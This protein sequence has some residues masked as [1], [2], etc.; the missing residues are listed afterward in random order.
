ML[1]MMELLKLLA[2]IEKGRS[3][4][5]DLL[6]LPRRD[7][8]YRDEHIPASIYEKFGA[9]FIQGRRWASGWPMG[10][11]ALAMDAFR[12]THE[13]WKSGEWDYSGYMLLES[14][15]VP[16]QANWLSALVSEWEAQPNHFLGH[17]IGHGTRIGGSHMNGNLIYHP[18]FF[19]AHPHMAYGPV[20]HM[21]WD[22]DWWPQIQASATAS[23]LIYSDYRLNTRKNPWKG[24]DYLWEPKY[25]REESNP[26]C[27]QALNPVWIHG[28]KGMEG[29]TCVRKKLLEK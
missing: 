8:K 18:S 20:K 28:I 16:L 27:G 1:Q 17:W 11:N 29:I 4:H 13:R 3:E 25:N 9:R 19:D 2:D 23:R 6:V 10:P 7:A 21:P 5:A 15:C 12:E 22:A 14:D 24:C 26:L